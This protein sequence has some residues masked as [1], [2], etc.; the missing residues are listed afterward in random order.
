MRKDYEYID[1]ATSICLTTTKKASKKLNELLKE[2]TETKNPAAEAKLDALGTVEE[3]YFYVES[4]KTMDEWYEDFVIQYAE[5]L[6]GQQ[7]KITREQ[8]LG[9][10]VDGYMTVQK[11]IWD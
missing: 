9:L 2:V 1:K 3:D 11:V 6:D 8:F 4:N 7:T 5:F 10:F